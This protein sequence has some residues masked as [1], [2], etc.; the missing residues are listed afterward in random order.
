[1][2]AVGKRELYELDYLYQSEH[3][4]NCSAYRELIELL[5]QYNESA[6][7]FNEKNTLVDND[8]SYNPVKLA[9]LKLIYKEMLI[10]AGMKDDEMKHNNL[11]SKIRDWFNQLGKMTSFLEGVNIQKPDYNKSVIKDEAIIRSTYISNVFD[12]YSSRYAESKTTSGKRSPMTA[13]PPRT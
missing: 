3:F 2:F 4:G 8:P 7:E 9:C 12:E 10:M 6:E 11:A 1:M 5:E 13:T